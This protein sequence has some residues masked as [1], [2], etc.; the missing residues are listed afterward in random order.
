MDFPF[1]AIKGEIMRLM[2]EE[3]GES[4]VLV[5]A[6]SCGYQKGLGEPKNNIKESV[7]RLK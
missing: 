1:W 6:F 7:K 2:I 5:K 4:R 3:R